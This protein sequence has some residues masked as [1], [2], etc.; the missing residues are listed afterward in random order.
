M[1]ILWLSLIAAPIAAAIVVGPEIWGARVDNRTLVPAPLI[2]PPKGYCDSPKPN[3]TV[4]PGQSAF[5]RDPPAKVFADFEAM[6]SEF[7]RVGARH[8]GFKKTG[9]M[10]RQLQAFHGEPECAAAETLLPLAQKIATEATR[11]EVERLELIRIAND[12]TGR[13]RFARD[14]EHKFLSDGQDFEIRAQGD[15]AA[16]LRIKWVL[17]GRPFV[18]KM[19]NEGDFMA[20]MKKRGFR[21]VVFTDGYNGTWRYDVPKD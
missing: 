18:Y 2:G 14:L 6:S 11:F 10:V 16:T 19:V 4:V 20:N 7:H 21:T 5:K 9:D 12:S 3:F 8:I 15:N 13:M 1:R 17:I